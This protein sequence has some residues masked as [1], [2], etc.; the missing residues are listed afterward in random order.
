MIA[1]GALLNGD[2]ARFLSYD[3]IEH[4]VALQLAGNVPSEM[5]QCARLALAFGYDEVNMNVGCPSGRVQSGQFGACLMAKPDLVAKC[6]DAMSQA[7]DIPVTI[8]TRIGIDHQDSYPFLKRFVST[9]YDAGCQVFIIH[10]RKAWLNG[11]NPK[12]NRKAPPLQYEVVFRLKQDFP[13]LEIILNGG[14]KLPEEA[15][16]QLKHVDGVMIGRGVYNN[17]YMFVEVD[18]LFYHDDHPHPSRQEVLEAY[19]PYVENQLAQGVRLSAITRHVMGLF[20]GLPGSRRWRR[21][22]SEAAHK[23]GASPHVLTQAARYLGTCQTQNLVKKSLR[24][25]RGLLDVSGK[26]RE[27]QNLSL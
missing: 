6:V 2:S 24:E 16:V 5:A 13:D 27:S 23:P 25:A 21:G 8:K 20:Q 1:T 26:A 14:L 4:P 22:I 10:A 11:L 9:V 18:R 12:Q 19:L 7:G 17:P 15:L 3:P